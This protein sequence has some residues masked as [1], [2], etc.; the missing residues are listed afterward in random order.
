MK[1]WIGCLLTGTLCLSLQACGSPAPAPGETAA[2]VPEATP[3]LHPRAHPR[4]CP[5]ARP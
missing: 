2:P 3:R 4:A 5:D 1:R